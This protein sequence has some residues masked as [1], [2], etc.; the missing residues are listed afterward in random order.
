MSASPHPYHLLK[1]A[2]AL[3]GTDT[4]GLAEAEYARAMDVARRYARIEAAVLGSDEARGVVL[5]P[6][7]VDAALGEIRARYDDEDAF[8]ASLH[9]TDLDLAGLTAALRR[10]LLVD[11]VLARVG[12]RAGEVG[13]TEAEIFYYTHLERF[14]VPEQR[15]AR[16]ILITV[17]EAYADNRPQQAEARIH[18]I[19]RRLAHKP[20]R[21]EEQA[22][23]HSECPTALHGGLLGKVPRGRLY[24][25]LDA[26]L[27]A[28]PAGALSEVVRSELGYHLLR[29]DA[30]EAARS[31]PYA[32]V[33][34]ALRTRL[35]EDRS[36]RTARHWLAT[37]LSP[38]GA[39]ASPDTAGCHHD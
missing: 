32:E 4:H 35:T 17:N 2:Q 10:D 31:L 19:A 39:R 9:H 20:A 33:A 21:F 23:K 15:V 29:C 18:E 12:A 7:T 34:D 16:H 1:A 38:G 36:R 13:A 30:I 26:A 25:E 27:F 6:D 37:L 3:F 8:G 5:A 22:I 24:P 28:L 14:Q 11:A